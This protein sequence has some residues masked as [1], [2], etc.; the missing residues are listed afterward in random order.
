MSTHMLGIKVLS[1]FSVFL[2][3]FVLAKLIIATSS[4]R[5]KKLFWSYQG[6]LRMILVKSK[7][8]L[9]KSQP[10]FCRHN[11]TCRKNVN[12]IHLK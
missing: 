12:L 7:D 10:H 5:V 6:I 4:M 3:H 11:D 1:N 8:F 9:R 2:H